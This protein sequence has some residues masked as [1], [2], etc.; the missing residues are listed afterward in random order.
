M[1]VGVSVSEEFWDSSEIYITSL[2]KYQQRHASKNHIY[3]RSS[4]G[5]F[6]AE[7]SEVLCHTGQWMTSMCYVALFP[8]IFP[9]PNSIHTK[10]RPATRLLLGLCSGA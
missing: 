2:S 1:E 7:P 9:T 4:R 10:C 8:S 6:L 5:K 3:V